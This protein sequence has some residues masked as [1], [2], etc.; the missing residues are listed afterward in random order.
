MGTT[1]RSRRSNV[2][3]RGPDTV[4]IVCHGHGIAGLGLRN[5]Q[6]A[7]GSC[8]DEFYGH[9]GNAQATWRARRKTSLSQRFFG[10][11]LSDGEKSTPRLWDSPLAPLRLKFSAQQYRWNC[12]D[13]EREWIPFRSKLGAFVPCSDHAGNRG[14]QAYDRKDPGVHHW[15]V[16]REARRDVAAADGEDRAVGRRQNEE[17]IRHWVAFGRKDAGGMHC[18]VD[19]N[20]KN[21]RSEKSGEHGADGPSRTGDCTSTWCVSFVH[22]FY[23]ERK[24]LNDRSVNKIF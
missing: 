11:F 21:G 2:S 5:E 20:G 10:K 6:G 1:L 3:H 17:S 7:D 4:R 15:P 12:Q 8:K 16:R 14:E 19:A 24:R 9:H 22:Y 23:L 13:D 18:E